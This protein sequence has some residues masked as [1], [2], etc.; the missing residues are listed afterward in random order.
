MLEKYYISKKDNTDLNIYRCGFEECAPDHAWGPGVRDHYSVHVILSGKGFFTLNGQTYTLKKGQG[1]LIFPGEVVHYKADSNHPWT[2]SWVGFHGLKAGIIL[3][4]SGLT[5]QTPIFNYGEEGPLTQSLTQL[6]AAARNEKTPE[7]MLTGFLYLFLSHLMENYRQS[8]SEKN[9]AVRSD[10]YVSRAVEYIEKNYVGELS[11]EGLS[12]YL[13]IDRSYLSSLF[14]KHLGL[15][16][17]E[18]IISF[19]MDKACDLLKNPQLSI[20]DVARSVGYED[21][22]Q[23]SKTF[24]KTKGEP[25]LSYRKRGEHQ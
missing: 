25:P 16:P 14:S 21:P 1:F 7:L 12:K 24:R 4:K 13:K 23:F 19:R 8:E 3:K 11:V 17:R 5:L 6:V 10:K 20:G 2:Y 18:F 15:S 22:L 9:R